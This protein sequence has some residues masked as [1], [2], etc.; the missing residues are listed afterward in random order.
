MVEVT[1]TAH[2]RLKEFKEREKVKEAFRIFLS[3]G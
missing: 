3:Y 2:A 1:P